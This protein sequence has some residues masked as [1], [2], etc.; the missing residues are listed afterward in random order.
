METGEAAVLCVALIVAAFI[1]PAWVERLRARAGRAAAQRAAEWQRRRTMLYDNLSVDEAQA[2]VRGWEEMTEEE[3]VAL[4]LS[5]RV[6]IR[7]IR[8]DLEKHKR[9]WGMK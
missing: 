4:S 7:K 6:E 5:R 8:E 1:V 3:R 9:A 2:I